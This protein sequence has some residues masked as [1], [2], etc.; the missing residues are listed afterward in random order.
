LSCDF[1]PEQIFELPKLKTLFIKYNNIV[2]DTDYNYIHSFNIE[3]LD[4][5]GYYLGDYRPLSEKFI[6]MDSLQ[7][8][9]LPMINEEDV[10]ILSKML[11]LDTLVLTGIL[12]NKYFRSEVDYIPDNINK[13]KNIRC[14]IVSAYA[15]I[16]ILKVK[17]ALPNTTIISRR[18]GKD[19]I[20]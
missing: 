8:L 13:L 4:S 12:N 20:W 11:N 19:I 7:T 10:E 16:N 14:L 15:K 17:E 18:H 3:E 5:L 9:S 6:T 2:S 1:V